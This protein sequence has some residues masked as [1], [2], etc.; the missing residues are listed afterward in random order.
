MGYTRPGAWDRETCSLVSM[1]AIELGRISH[2]LG[3]GGLSFELHAWWI[4]QS[5]DLTLLQGRGGRLAGQLERA[6][7]RACIGLFNGQPAW[8]GPDD[9]CVSLCSKDFRKAAVPLE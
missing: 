7:R 2:N 1:L 9:S 8:P 5:P 3:R 6:C 4:N